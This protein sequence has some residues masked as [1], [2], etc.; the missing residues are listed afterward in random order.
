MVVAG[1]QLHNLGTCP[2][3]LSTLAP[4]AQEQLRE[5][6]KSLM[7]GIGAIVVTCHTAHIARVWCKA[8][9]KCLSFI[10]KQEGPTQVAQKRRHKI[11]MGTGNQVGRHGLYS[12]H[13]SRV[14]VAPKNA[15]NA[16]TKRQSGK[17]P[18]L[19]LA[20]SAL[21]T[22][23]Y[24]SVVFCRVWTPNV[25][26]LKHQSTTWPYQPGQRTLTSN[27]RTCGSCLFL[28]NAL[29]QAF[30]SHKSQTTANETAM[31]SKHCLYLTRHHPSTWLDRIAFGQLCFRYFWTTEEWQ[32][33]RHG[34]SMENIGWI[35]VPS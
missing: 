16:E 17:V 31:P 21:T 7:L 1:G 32:N 9:I 19:L 27:G 34:N 24:S 12:G 4:S 33:M 10:E 23:A 25:G 22:G 35:P 28:G 11:H 2:F 26:Y 18:T 20:L 13:Y 6:G 14:F 30:Q 15:Q 8:G 5:E 3:K 29:L